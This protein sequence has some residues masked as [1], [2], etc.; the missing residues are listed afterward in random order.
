MAEEGDDR[1]L[2]EGLR[3]GD[4]DALDAAYDRYRARLFAFL[5]RLS[6][7]RPLAEDLM[8]ETFVRL[9]QR[10]R[11]LDADVALRPW[12][13]RTG[14][15]LYFD[16]R[17]RALLDFDRL[18]EL[19]LWSGTA[20]RVDETPFD[21]AEA[22]ETER[23]LERAMGSI[24]EAYRE[25]LLLVVVEGMTPGEAAQIAGVRDATLRKRLQRGRDILS[26]V[27]SDG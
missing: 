1:P 20:K 25:A 26:E 21:L 17:R 27:L 5:A 6:R 8:Q 14:R 18:A 23:R 3:R 24:P 22:S 9:A 16:H 4:A 10:A 19:A 13:F 12:L 11:E 2:V 7:S 15:N